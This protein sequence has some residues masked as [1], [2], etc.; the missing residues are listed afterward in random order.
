MGLEES[1]TEET[2]A[3]Q[4]CLAIANFVS[5]RVEAVLNEKTNLAKKKFPNEAA[6]DLLVACKEFLIRV[7]KE[8][9]PSYPFL[10][11]DFIAT[12]QSINDSVFKILFSDVAENEGILNATPKKN[13][14]I[15]TAPIL[16]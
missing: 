2:Q 12:I 14:A 3:R 6:Q 4:S 15:K 5:A 8:F 16:L 9:D 13:M 11:Q 10:P 7:S 1:Q